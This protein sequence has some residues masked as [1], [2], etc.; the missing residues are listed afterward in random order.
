MIEVPKTDHPLHSDF[1]EHEIRGAQAG[2]DSQTCFRVPASAR[3][4]KLE[5]V[6]LPAITGT[7]T[8]KTASSDYY[9]WPGV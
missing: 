5:P 3:T 1:P 4:R 7:G 8:P 9:S 6:S 2:P